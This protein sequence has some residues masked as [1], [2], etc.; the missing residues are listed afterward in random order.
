[1]IHKYGLPLTDSDWSGLPMRVGHFPVRGK[2]EEISCKSHT[3]LLWTGGMS[4]VHLAY[5]DLGGKGEEARFQRRSGM[6]DVLPAGLALEEV[7]WRN[8]GPGSSCVSVTFPTSSLHQLFGAAH[9]VPTNVAHFRLDHVVR[10]R[11]LI[12]RRRLLDHQH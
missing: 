2:I 8:E 1:M 9:L 5:R 3:V 6:I 11:D 4:E 10:H 12:M 7:R